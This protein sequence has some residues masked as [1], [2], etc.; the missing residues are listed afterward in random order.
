MEYRVIRANDYLAHYGVKGMKWG[1][2]RYQPYG[3]GGYNP[4][5]TKKK[6]RLSSKQK[7]ILIAAGAIA[8]TA[9]LATYGVYKAKNLDPSVTSKV[10]GFLKRTGK[11]PV[12]DI[13][14]SKPFDFM[15]DFKNFKEK[16]HIIIGD[17]DVPPYST[18]RYQPYGE[19]GIKAIPKTPKKLS[20]FEF[21]MALNMDA[22]GKTSSVLIPKDK[23]GYAKTFASEMSKD[24]TKWGR[25]EQKEYKYWYDYMMGRLSYL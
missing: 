5:E 16:D 11:T 19:G 6:H 22:N 13:P 15:E 3:E 9:A 2:R 24:A 10:A 25:N 20:D 21:D 14:E 8:V 12:S 18:K 23:E 4:K 17:G 1:V 7:K